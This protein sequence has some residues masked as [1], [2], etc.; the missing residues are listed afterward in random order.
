ML[1]VVKKSQQQEI[2][3][4]YNANTEEALARVFLGSSF[5]VEDEIFG[6]MIDLRM[7]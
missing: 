1:Q 7:R 4:E 2:A 6:V 5:S 3:N